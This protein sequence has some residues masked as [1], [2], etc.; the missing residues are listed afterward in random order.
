MNCNK[1][2]ALIRLQP[3]SLLGLEERKQLD[4][5][6]KDC[7]ICVLQSRE[8]Q[9]AYTTLKAPLDPYRM[10]EDRV[11]ESI[12]AKLPAPGSTAP[13][14]KDHEILI[15]LS[16]CY[17]HDSLARS[18]AVYC[19]SCL[20]PH[21][22]ECFAEHG[23]CSAIGCRELKTVAPRLEIKASPRRLRS[24]PKYIAGSIIFLAF[25]TVAALQVNSYNED[26]E[27]MSKKV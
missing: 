17:C 21:H 14:N 23:L 24:K 1:Y 25:A 2:E 12:L 9:L 22:G 15:T 10:N 13:A 18:Q 26:F 27:A 5:H 7:S 6:L 19:A 11:F 8:L 20:S 4:K 16:C 3:A